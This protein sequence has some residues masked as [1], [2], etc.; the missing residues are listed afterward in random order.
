MNVRRSDEVID[1]CQELKLTTED[2]DR[3]DELGRAIDGLETTRAIESS[4]K[5][6]AGIPDVIFGLRGTSKEP[7][8]FIL[9]HS[10]QHVAKKVAK[11]SSTII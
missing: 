8:A 10:A 4:M 11:I 6:G 5:R 2:F 7:M 3:A 1:A 9:G